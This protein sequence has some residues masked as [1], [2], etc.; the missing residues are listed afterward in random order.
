VF[1]EIVGRDFPIE[2]EYLEHMYGDEL[3]DEIILN[4]IA[5]LVTTLVVTESDEGLLERYCEAI[6]QICLGADPG[7]VQ[8]VCDQLL[9]VVPQPVRERLG[10]YLGD[11]TLELCEALDAD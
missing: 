9:A 2:L 7:F 3:T 10:S 8:V 4:E 5:A 6:E 11:R 1:T